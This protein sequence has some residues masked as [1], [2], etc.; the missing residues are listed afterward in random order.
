VFDA[1]PWEAENIQLDILH[2]LEQ[3]GQLTMRFK[4]SQYLD[5]REQLA[6]I[7]D[8]VLS[9]KQQTRDTPYQIDTLKIMV[10]GTTESR[11]AAMFVA[12]QG[13]PDNFGETVLTQSELS[14]LVARGV[15]SELDIHFHA[16][17]ERAI[18]YSLNAIEDVKKQR[19]ENDVRF[20]LSH[21][22]VMADE[23]IA[24]F[25]SLGVIG[26]GSLLWAIHD[27]EGEKFLTPDQFNRYYRYQSL[28]DAGATLS[29]GCDFPSHGGGLKA[30]APLFNI[31]V[32][33]T[34]Q[35]AGQPDAAI[36]P[37]KQERLAVADLL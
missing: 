6:T 15:A 27:T 4:G 23:D 34:R 20:T 37:S 8:E 16:L 1:G 11:T 9:L 28:L 26:Q 5:S 25:A 21:I 22:Q 29:F 13:E 32:G 10:D 2:Q 17:G 14:D 12:Y 31:E 3:S 33:H 36:Q 7:V 24:R 18:S 35:V 19:P 30:V